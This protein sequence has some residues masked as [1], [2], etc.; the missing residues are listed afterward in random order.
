M[1]SLCFTL[2]A[3]PSHRHAWPLIT[4]TSPPHLS[5]CQTLISS[6]L[7]SLSTHLLKCPHCT[8][9]QLYWS[10]YILIFN[11][12][13]TVPTSSSYF[14]YKIYHCNH[15]P[16][17]N[18]ESRCLLEECIYLDTLVSPPR[19]W[20]QVFLLLPFCRLSSHLIFLFIPNLHFTLLGWSYKS[21]SQSRSFFF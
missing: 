15:D 9:L 19:K 11:Q 12:P 18:S 6:N 16:L 1:V 4:R 20:G 3:S 21:V 10:W 7:L 14:E 17:T 5:W 13:L 2:A 8:V